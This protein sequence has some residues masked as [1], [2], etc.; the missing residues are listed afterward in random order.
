MDANEEDVKSEVTEFVDKVNRLGTMF[1][2]LCVERHVE[3]QEKYGKYTFLG[4]DVTRMM[5]E[6]L[7]DTANYCRYQAVKLMLLQEALE[8]QIA[9]SGLIADGEEEITLGVKAFRGTK[10]VGWSDKK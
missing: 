8:S 4:N 1:E 10:D 2:N 6:E 7:A 3:G 9:G 5:L